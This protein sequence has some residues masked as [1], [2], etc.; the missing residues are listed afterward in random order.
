MSAITHSHNIGKKNRPLPRHSRARGCEECISPRARVQLIRNITRLQVLRAA[1]PR[2][3]RLKAFTIGTRIH[4]SHSTTSRSAGQV[5]KTVTIDPHTRIRGNRRKGKRKVA[6]GTPPWRIFIFGWKSALHPTNSIRVGKVRGHRQPIKIRAISRGRGWPLVIKEKQA[7]AG[8]RH[9][10]RNAGLAPIQWGNNLTTIH[11]GTHGG[12]TSG[13][14]KQTTKIPEE[15]A[16][17]GV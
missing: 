11:A 3:N 2:K 7:S 12:H 5:Q 1:P 13:K 6:R 9:E 8:K 15:L 10:G 16:F 4:V 17:L 14:W